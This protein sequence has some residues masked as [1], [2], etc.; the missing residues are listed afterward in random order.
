MRMKGV[1]DTDTYTSLIAPNDDFKLG[2]SPTL[3]ASSFIMRFVGR[4]N[5]P[6]GPSKSLHYD[7]HMPQRLQNKSPASM[8]GQG[9]PWVWWLSS[10][11]GDLDII[12]DRTE[13]ILRIPYFNIYVVVDFVTDYMTRGYRCDVEWP[14][15]HHLQTIPRTM[16]PNDV[17][18]KKDVNSV[19]IDRYFSIGIELPPHTASSF[20]KG[21][22]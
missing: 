16:A 1:N 10:S 5:C 15:H 2:G 11:C 9:P 20:L 7:P 17:S 6:S 4:E 22:S 14:S 18:S 3:Q 8:N 21:R 19:G 12:L 13:A